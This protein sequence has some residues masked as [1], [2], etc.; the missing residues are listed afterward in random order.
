[1]ICKFAIDATSRPALKGDSVL[2]LT[3]VERQNLDAVSEVLPFWNSHD[4]PRILEFYDEG[5]TWRNVALGDTYQGKDEV[6]EY[7]EQMFSAFPDLS[8]EVS[9]KVASGD[10]V[11]EQWII[12][13][14]HLGSFMGIPPTGR[15][16]TIPGMSMVH[17]R[18]A[19]FLRDDFYYDAAGVLH[20]MGI[21]PPLTIGRTMI[22]QKLL[23]MAVHRVKVGAALGAAGALWLAAS[24]LRRS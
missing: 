6:R 11:A 17:M 2:E 1:M 19:R 18:N 4:I 20:Q 16:I 10:F 7:L 12:R 3:T 15:S 14:T 21:F 22:G 13:G 23:W 5:I 9:Q 8:F 24:R